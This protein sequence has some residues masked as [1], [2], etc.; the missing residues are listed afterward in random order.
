[1]ELGIENRV[2]I[3]T[4]ASRGLGRATAE[5]L[6]AE[7]VRL[8]VNARSADQL[9]ELAAASETE[10]VSVPGDLND[11]EIPGQLVETALQRFGRLDILVANNAGPPAGGAFAIS[12][13]QI[14][15][16]L[17]GNLLAFVRLARAA[18]PAMSS[19]GWG[20]VL[21]IASGAAK[22]PMDD[23]ALSNLSRPGLWGWAKTAATELAGDGV[24]IN[25]V[26]PG[27]HT[28][29]RAVEL[30]RARPYAGDP[31]AFGRIVAFLCSTHTDFMTG[32]A[33]VVDGG[34]VKGL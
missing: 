29:E 32:T 5:A 14:E 34:R 9:G 33:I 4:A 22:Q 21:M 1:M 25:L 18:V 6:A 24:T 27:L 7:G 3:V 11:P 26:C 12:D 19:G 8:V 20:R 15:D 2:A 23:L 28:T 16:A 17:N 31:K 13:A 10:V 30:G